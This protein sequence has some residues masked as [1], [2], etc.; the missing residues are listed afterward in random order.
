MLAAL[1]D[2]PQGREDGQA[3]R[4]DEPDPGRPAEAAP[5]EQRVGDGYEG[6]GQERRAD[7][8]RAAG[9]ALACLGDEASAGA[10]RD[11]RDRH[12]D[13]EDGAPAP[14]EEIRA[15]EQPA[16]HE[17][18]GG[19]EAED[20]PVEAEYL[21]PFLGGEDRSEGGQD[22][23]DHRRRYGSLDNASRDQLTRVLREPG[24][25]ARRPK[26]A[27]P[28]RKTRLRPRESPKLPE[29]ISVDAKASM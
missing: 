28:T 1:L 22:L 11:E 17:P 25:E 27:T 10:E 15:R 23:R 3:G 26:A 24:G 13:Q 4:E 8:V 21:A 7:D 12:V 20:R 19:R 18:K 9:G 14:A 16:E 2:D 5:L 6:R 29:T